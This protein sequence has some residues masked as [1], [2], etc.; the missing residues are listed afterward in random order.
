M[1]RILRVTRDRLGSFSGYSN[2][3]VNRGAQSTGILTAASD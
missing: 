1:E 2:N 3:G